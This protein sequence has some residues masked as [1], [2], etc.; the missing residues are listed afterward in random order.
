MFLNILLF[1]LSVVFVGYLYV[2]RC[3]SFWADH[4]VPFIKPSFPFGNLTLIGRR[5]HFALR[6]AKFYEQMK[7]HKV[8]FAGLYFMLRPVVLITDLKLMQSVLIKDFHHFDDRGFFYNEKKDPLSAHLFSLDAARWKPLRSKLTPTFTSGK[9]KF[10]F[11]TIVNVAHEFV[12]CLREMLKNDN[13]VE[14]RDLLG[15]FTTDV[16]GTTAFGIECNSLKDPD[17]KFRRM[18][19]KTFD[20]PKSSSFERAIMTV[21][22][23]FSRFLGLRVHHKDVTDFFMNSVKETIEYREQHNV[24]RNDFMDLLIKLKN[25]EAHTGAGG[26]TVN[27]IAANAFVVIIIYLFYSLS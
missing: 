25:D 6:M 7:G 23:R 22:Q 20:E 11:P 1:L 18:G 10:M 24:H 3:F 4:G 8:P 9:M 21:S 2:K 15:R 12:D 19:K 17:A 5:D 14:I 16:I 13:E 26:L 27:E